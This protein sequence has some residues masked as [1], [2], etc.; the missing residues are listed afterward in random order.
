[1]PDSDAPALGIV[2]EIRRRFTAVPERVFDAWTR[3]EALKRWWCPP[4]WIP[5]RTE[6]DL[7]VGGA[8]CIGMRQQAGDRIVCVVGHFLDVEPG[9]KLVY[10]WMWEG[11]F[12]QMPQTRVTVLF[13]PAPVGTEVVL[14]H[15]GFP[16]IAL[17]QQHR[18]GWIAGC[19]R[20]DAIL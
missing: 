11:A 18:A 10:T 8:F 4:G 5:D 2:L 12:E 15:E 3:P 9:A 14:R 17:W 1:M 13:L 6:I 16:S 7:R 20:M 19:D